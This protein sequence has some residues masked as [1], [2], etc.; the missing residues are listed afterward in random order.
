MSFDQINRQIINKPLRDD[1]NI[2]VSNV[3]DK[4][5]RSMKEGLREDSEG[6]KEKKRKE[7]REENE[8]QFKNGYKLQIRH[9][10]LC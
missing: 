2:Y 5:G 4:Q 9:V 7:Q 1:Y 3:S 6:R 8:M 10:F